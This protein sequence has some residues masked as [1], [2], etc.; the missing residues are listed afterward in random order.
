MGI[1]FEQRDV[2][3]IDDPAPHPERSR[4]GEE[5]VGQEVEVEGLGA[6]EV[7]AVRAGE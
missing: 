7:G 2:G 5:L 1:A 6:Q 4:L 3:A